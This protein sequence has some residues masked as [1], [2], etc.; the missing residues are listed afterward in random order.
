VRVG[1]HDFAAIVVLVVLPA[2]GDSAVPDRCGKA[3]MLLEII[4]GW[5]NHVNTPLGS[6]ILASTL[7]IMLAY[8]NE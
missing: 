3:T 7:P 5:N 4:T 8:Q 1:D 6:N 2:E